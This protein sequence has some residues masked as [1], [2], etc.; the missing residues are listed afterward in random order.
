MIALFVQVFY[1]YAQTDY[2]D[3]NS[4]YWTEKDLGYNDVTIG[5]GTIIYSFDSVQKQYRNGTLILIPDLTGTPDGNTID[6]SVLYGYGIG[7]TASDTAF[8][9]DGDTFLYPANDFDVGKMFVSPLSSVKMSYGKA[10]QNNNSLCVSE[11][12]VAIIDGPSSTLAYYGYLPEEGTY[13][14]WTGEELINAGDLKGTGTD[15]KISQQQLDTTEN[16]SYCVLTYGRGWRLPTDIEVGHINDQE[17]LDQGF[18]EAYRGLKQEYFWT[19]S[20][21]KIYNVKRW[22]VGISDGFWEN[23]AGFVYVGNYV[24]CVYPGYGIATSINTAEDNTR[25]PE[26]F[27]NPVTDRLFIRLDHGENA[28]L[29]MTDMIGNTI[30]IERDIYLHRANNMYSIE[31]KDLPAGIYLLRIIYRDYTFARTFKITKIN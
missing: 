22:A 12:C 19:S 24:R 7:G 8:Q 23:C 3:G 13:Q 28:T 2:P 10:V 17:E 21:F 14:L 26:I 15:Q 6:E 30:D 1:L 9:W 11:N 31:M 27:P 18:D 16:M 20:L 4:A 25:N 5:G 29:L